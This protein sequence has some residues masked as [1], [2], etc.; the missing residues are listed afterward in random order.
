MH[1][2]FFRTHVR[3]DSGETQV[4]GTVVFLTKSVNGKRSGFLNGSSGMKFLRR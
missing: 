2:E 1:L 3:P 4:S